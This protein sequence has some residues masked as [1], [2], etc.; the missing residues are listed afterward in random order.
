MHQDNDTY[1]LRQLFNWVVVILSAA[2]IVALT[3]LYLFV[4]YPEVLP[5]KSMSTYIKFMDLISNV[6]SN[7]IAALIIYISLFFVFQR[8][9][10]N[11]S[12]TSASSKSA[13][14]TISEAQHQ[15]S[16]STVDK[17]KREQV[18]QVL[19]QTLAKLIENSPRDAVNDYDL[20]FLAKNGIISEAQ[21]NALMIR[22]PKG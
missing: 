6:I 2:V 9:R 5:G 20:A 22:L 10:Q 16:L 12:S 14:N 21:Y 15:A 8:W 3:L 4:T 13:S 11:L 19:F 7:L 17:D 1:T 18:Q